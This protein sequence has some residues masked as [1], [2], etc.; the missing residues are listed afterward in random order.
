MTTAH[1]QRISN[2][3]DKDEKIEAYKSLLTGLFEKHDASGIKETVRHI[4]SASTIISRP[5]LKEIVDN[6]KKK[7]PTNYIKMSLWP[8]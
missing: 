6:L 5:V 2:I 7:L 1:L 4:V 3:N 8:Y